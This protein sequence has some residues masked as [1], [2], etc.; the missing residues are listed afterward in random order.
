MIDYTA[1]YRIRYGE[2]L[3]Q[4]IG[5]LKACRKVVFI[6][7]VLYNYTINPNSVTQS[8][9]IKKYQVDSTV[10]RLV[11]EFLEREDV[12]AERDWE[13]YSQYCCRLLKE[14]LQM[15]CNFRASYGELV[16]ILRE[17]RED[18]YFCKIIF[19]GQKNW[20]FRC[21]IREQFH[22]LILGIRIR[23]SVA[24]IILRYRKIRML[25]TAGIYRK[26]V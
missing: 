22:L 13:K 18:K 24:K 17:I 14:E 15:V 5:A 7:D 20:R 21:L 8:R 12:F 2:D 3:L 26:R 4:S 23:T 1:Y 10:R 9:T 16:E 19:L 25:L 11:W 6:P